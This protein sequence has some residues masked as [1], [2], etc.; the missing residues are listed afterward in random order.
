M[1]RMTR[2]QR[3]QHNRVLL[4]EAGERVFA[5]RGVAGASLDDVALEAGLTK[6]AVYSNFRSKGELIL[7]VIRYRQTLSQEA[8]GFHAILDRA[9]ND[10]ER[11]EA[12][13]D[14]W[15]LTA[16]SGERSSYARL[17]FDFI[18]YAL[19]DEHLTA[20]F[21]E[22]ISPAGDI[23]AGESPIPTDS[24][25]ARIPPGD[26]FRILTALD[27]GL[28]ALGLF[29]PENVKPELYKTAVL[30]LAQTLYDAS[31]Q[32]DYAQQP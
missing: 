12:W 16:Q 25:F 1:A 32:S 27:L 5:A 19:R 10:Y 22:F 8:Q 31:D 7:E 18:P 9:S 13:C 20:R 14:I 6:G 23:S 4:L 26:Q 24:R 2:E 11:L 28:S 3:Q 17:L 15:V 21:L 30:S 29:D